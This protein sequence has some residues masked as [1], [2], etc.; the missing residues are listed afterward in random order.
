MS[1]EL[2]VAVVLAGVAVGVFSA[3][4]GVGGGLL[5]V[6]LIVLAFDETQQVAEGTSLLVIVPTALAG[7][8]ALRGR[9]LV[10]WSLVGLIAIGGALGSFAGATVALSIPSDSLTKAFAAVTCGIGISFI[11]RGWR[12]YRASTT[13]R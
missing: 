7:L 3:L 2:A 8:V 10:S 13:T 1:A 11:A 5:M 9:S 6:P 12:S 4:F